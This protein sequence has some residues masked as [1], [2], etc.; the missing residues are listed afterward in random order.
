MLHRFEEHYAQRIATEPFDVVLGRFAALW[1][2][3]RLLNPELGCGDHWMEDLAADLRIAR[4]VNGLP[5][6]SAP[7]S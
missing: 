1:A 5:P 6:L 3:A 4:A 2:H 7:A